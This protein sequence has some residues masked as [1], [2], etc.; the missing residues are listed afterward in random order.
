MSLLP[1]ARFGGMTLALLAVVTAA[2]AGSS[3]PRSW[4]TLGGSHS[5]ANAVAIQP[6]GKIVLAGTTMTATSTEP[7]R[8]LVI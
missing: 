5:E 3:L 7:S 1:I 2:M 6:D 8:S 4:N